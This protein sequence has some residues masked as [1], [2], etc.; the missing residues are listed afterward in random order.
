MASRAMARHGQQGD[1]KH[2]P[3]I[4]THHIKVDRAAVWYW[5][6]KEWCFLCMYLLLTCMLSTRQSSTRLQPPLRMCL[7]LCNF[8]S[9]L[10]H[11]LSRMNLQL[12]VTVVMAWGYRQ[13][14]M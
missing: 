4:S 7:K 5:F 6:A 2:R 12:I 11:R 1:G 14:L 10:K 8:F 3:Y 9:V 13:A